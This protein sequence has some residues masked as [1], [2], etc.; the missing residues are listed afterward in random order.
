L[1]LRSLL[2]SI[3]KESLD[4]AAIV[5]DATCLVYALF[6]VLPPF[7]PPVPFPAYAPVGGGICH[8]CRIPREERRLKILPPY[9]PAPVWSSG[10]ITSLSQVYF[11][12]QPSPKP[13]HSQFYPFLLQYQEPF[14]HP[15]EIETIRE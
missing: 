14:F 11:D 5:D 1:T 7:T 2:G 4:R 13:S 10:V 6:A 12:N 3:K 15:I 8:R 9:I